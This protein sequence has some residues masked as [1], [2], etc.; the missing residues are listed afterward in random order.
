MNFG[1]LI[2]YIKG[3]IFLEKSFTKCGQ[4]AMSKSFTRAVEI[5]QNLAADHLVLPHIKFFQKT[6]SLKLVF[7]PHF[8]HDVLKEKHASS[9]ILSADQISLFFCLCFGK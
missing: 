6:K 5:H 1:Q 8:L 7:L 4:E 9:Y 2:G 3:N